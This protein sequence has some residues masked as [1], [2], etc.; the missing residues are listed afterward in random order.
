LAF[1]VGADREGAAHLVK[2]PAGI[3]AR[4][5]GTAIVAGQEIQVRL[6]DM[7]LQTRRTAVVR[8]VSESTSTETRQTTN[9][10]Y[11]ERRDPALHFWYCYVGISVGA[12]ASETKEQL[13]ERLAV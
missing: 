1:A 5:H 7:E 10:K 13:M 11:R 6:I 9:D 2:A 12:R 8:I 3:V 4:K